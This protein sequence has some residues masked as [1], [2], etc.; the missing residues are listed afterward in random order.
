MKTI[1]GVCA[2]DSFATERRGMSVTVTT[3][4]KMATMTR[5]RIL[6]FE[7]I[8]VRFARLNHANVMVSELEVRR[9]DFNLGHV[10]S[11]TLF[12]GN[13]T[14]W[15]TTL[16]SG[17]ALQGMTSETLLIVLGSTFLKRLVRIVASGATD[18]SIV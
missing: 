11:R 13:G 17:F 14:T 6:G 7:S 1:E 18:I 8:G 4:S 15:R 12:N 10:T 5:F 3:A 9:L 2:T 16:S